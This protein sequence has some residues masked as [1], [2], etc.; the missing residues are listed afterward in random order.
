MTHTRIWLK[1][2]YHS[3]VAFV[4]IVFCCTILLFVLSHY[5]NQYRFWERFHWDN[6][7]KNASCFFNISVVHRWLCLELE[8][9]VNQNHYLHSLKQT[10]YSF[11]STYFCHFPLNLGV[12][13]K[14]CWFFLAYE[15]LQ[16]GTYYL[17]WH[18]QKMLNIFW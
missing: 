3:V 5:L 17:Q 10:F 14:T 18:I 8:K 2:F 12:N 15:Y 4:C 11:L 9:Y 1:R 13:L 7:I 6:V 16:L